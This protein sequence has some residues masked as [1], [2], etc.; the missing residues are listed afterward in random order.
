MSNP[1]ERACARLEG[2]DCT[3]CILKEPLSFWCE[4]RRCH[5]PTPVLGC[6]GYESKEP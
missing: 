3:H 1:G 4:L 5:L 6:L 2:P